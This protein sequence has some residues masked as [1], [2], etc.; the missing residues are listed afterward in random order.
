[1]CMSCPVKDKCTKSSGE[2]RI[3]ANPILDEMHAKVDENLSTPEGKEMKKQRSIQTEGAFGVLKYD[4]GYE[5]IRRRGTD[6]VRTELL[7]ILLGFNLRKYHNKKHR[8]SKLEN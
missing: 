4:Y 3:S 1:M 2:R 8:Q 7:L 5:R 6:N